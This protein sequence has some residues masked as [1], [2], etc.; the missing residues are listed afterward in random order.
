MKQPADPRPFVL[1]EAMSAQPDLF[2]CGPTCL[3]AIYR[4]HGN[5]LPLAQVIAE[6][7]PLAQGG[8]LAVCLANHALARGYTARLHT[9]NLEVF[10]LTWLGLPRA[11][12]VERLDRRLARRRGRRFRAAALAYREF[13]IRGGEIR[14][15]DLTVELLTKPLA[16]GWPVIAG[17]SA[18]Y[19]YHEPREIQATNQP[20]D[21]QGEPT[22]HFVVLTA[23]DRASREL[24]IADPLQPNPMA[25]GP[26][27]RV[28]VRRAITAI[29][30][31]ILTYDAN[32]LLLRPPA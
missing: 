15:E 21:I 10:D 11:E 25:P 26:G 6:I 27:Y 9:Y 5:E 14:I 16:A 1:P 28:D 3:H 8:T 13:L 2:T 29:L 24:L 4:Y 20:D 12:I 17:L 19:L 22:G 32:L 30:L 18:T 7:P 31:G 23:Y